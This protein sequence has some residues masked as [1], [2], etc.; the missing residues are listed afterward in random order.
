MNEALFFAFLAATILLLAVP[1]PSC[2]LA[3]SQ[4]VRY[5]PRAA[6]MTV[7]GDAMGTVVHITIATLGFQLLIGVASST[8]PWLQIAGGSYILY[9]AYESYRDGGGTEAAVAPG[10][11][12][13][14]EAMFVGFVACVSNPKAIIFFVAL[15][16]GFIDTDYNIMLQ[17]FVYGTIFIVLDALSILAYAMLGVFMFKSR[18]L[19]KVDYRVVSAVGLGLIGCFLLVQG[20]AAVVVIS[21]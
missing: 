4:A 2:A 6:V 16:P 8:L 19:S 10:K 9:L 15:F 21:S 18:F 12:G 7:V 1:G 20:C 13:S 11:S 3:T 14:I 17:S 5:G